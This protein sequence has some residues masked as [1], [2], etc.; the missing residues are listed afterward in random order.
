MQ[1]TPGYTLKQLWKVWV[2]EHLEMLPSMDKA[3]RAIPTLEGQ[4]H[5]EVE[6][7]EMIPEEREVVWDKL[8]ILLE[9]I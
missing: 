1:A 5:Y 8:M 7:A 6:L 9:E 2:G 3:V 4:I